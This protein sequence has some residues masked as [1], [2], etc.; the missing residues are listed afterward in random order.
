MKP[1]TYEGRTRST[2]PL[3]ATAMKQPRTLAEA[4]K[5]LHEQ[6]LPREVLDD[7]TAAE[8]RAEQMRRLFRCGDE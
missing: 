3:R 7:A 1:T 4:L 2:A 6:K 5:M 8:E